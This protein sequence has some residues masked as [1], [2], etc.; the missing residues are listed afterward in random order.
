M[1]PN[2]TIGG[3]SGRPNSAAPFGGPTP[4]RGEPAP[5]P[6]IPAMRT[7]PPPMRG[8]VV[9]VCRLSQYCCRI[10]IGSY[11]VQILCC[12]PPGILEGE[13]EGA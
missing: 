4:V 8:M 13:G 5:E 1:I 2:N 9:V 3:G 7:G 12:Q 11:Y 10:I 6:Y